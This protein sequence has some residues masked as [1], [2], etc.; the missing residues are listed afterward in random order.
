MAIDRM[1]ALGAYGNAIAAGKAAA[2]GEGAAAGAA[3]GSGFADLLRGA[4]EQT[5]QAQKAGEAAAQAAVRGEADLSEV[6]MAVGNAEIALQSVV[7]VRDRVLQAYQEVM[8][9]PI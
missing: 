3:T 4:V 9:M 1:A 5:T 6:V 2:G 7:A 8:R